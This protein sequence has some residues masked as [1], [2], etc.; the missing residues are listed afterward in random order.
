[1]AR[2]TSTA[3]SIHGISSRTTAISRS[4]KVPNLLRPCTVVY[5]KSRARSTKPSVSF[6]QTHK[7]LL[8]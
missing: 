5:S 4:T 8:P 2:P 1:S 6:A 7:R 3:A